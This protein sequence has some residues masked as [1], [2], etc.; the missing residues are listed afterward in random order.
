MAVAY[1]QRLGQGTATA[2]AFVTLFTATSSMDTVVRD[3]SLY[4]SSAAANRLYLFIET[5]GVFFPILTGEVEA[6]GTL[7]FSG[8]Q[9]LQVGDSLV[10]SCDGTSTI[11]AI[12]TGYQFFPPT[13]T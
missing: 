10:A 8:R 1:T 3:V 9:R 7:R 11:Q 4:N 5:G 6:R 13:P 2:P 12:A